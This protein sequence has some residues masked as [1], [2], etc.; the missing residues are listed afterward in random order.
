M[1]SKPGYSWNAARHL[2]GV[3]QVFIPKELYQLL[4]FMR[5]S[6]SKETEGDPT[7]A[8]H[9]D[10][11]D[12]KDLGGN[13]PQEPSNISR[14]PAPAINLGFR[15]PSF[16]QLLLALPSPNLLLHKQKLRLLLLFGHAARTAF[17]AVGMRQWQNSTI[18]HLKASTVRKEMPHASRACAMGP[19]RRPPDV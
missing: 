16:D 6:S 13:A 12:E 18:K 1:L 8:E 17:C 5:N 9:A 7:V 14:M 19:C 4:L 11:I 10:R 15:L 2:F 3:C